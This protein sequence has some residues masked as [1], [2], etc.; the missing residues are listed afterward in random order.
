MYLACACHL[1]H[2]QTDPPPPPAQ[3]NLTRARTGNN[4]SA[5][6]VFDNPSVFQASGELGDITG[7][8]MVDD[9]GELN[10]TDV[11]AKFVNGKPSVSAQ[12]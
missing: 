7:L 6:F 4:G 2:S 8:F 11:K 3:V 1:S 5:L 9:E 10:T 12:S